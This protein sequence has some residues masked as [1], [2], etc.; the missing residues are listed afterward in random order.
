[1]SDEATTRTRKP[2]PYTTWAK[3]NEHAKK[4]RRAAERA[5]DLAERA[6]V[7]A[8]KA[9]DLAEL[10]DLADEE[11]Q[12]ALQAL[13]ASIEAGKIDTDEDGDDDE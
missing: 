10:R 13:Q 7:A 1:M 5:D 2:N 12:V 9:R 11:E 3:A 6:R 8:E 4:A